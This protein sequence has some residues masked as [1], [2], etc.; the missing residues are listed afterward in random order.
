[1]IYASY[2]D[3]YPL[4]ANHG[5]RANTEEFARQHPIPPDRGSWL[6]RAALD[7]KM[8]QIPDV[9]ADPNIRCTPKQ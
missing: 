5:F 8:V 2:G 6:G 9:L 1:M 7:G 3:V 4:A